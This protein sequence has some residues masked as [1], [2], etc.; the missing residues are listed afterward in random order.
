M[1]PPRPSFPSTLATPSS[2]AKQCSALLLPRSSASL[3][4]AAG[5]TAGRRDWPQSLYR[6]VVDE[7]VPALEISWYDVAQ[8][9]DG[10]TFVALCRLLDN[11]YPPRT[12]PFTL[13]GLDNAS[14]LILHLVHRV[15]CGTPEDQVLTAGYLTTQLRLPGVAHL[16]T[17]QSAAPV[18]L[19]PQPV[20]TAP[21]AA[22][23]GSA[24]AHRDAGRSAQ[25]APILPMP[26]G[27]HSSQPERQPRRFQWR[28]TDPS[29]TVDLPEPAAREAATKGQ[30]EVQR[31]PLGR[32]PQPRQPPQHGPRPE[33]A[34]HREGPK[35]TEQQ[36][37]I[38]GSKG[39]KRIRDDAHDGVLPKRRGNPVE[40]RPRGSS[41]AARHKPRQPESPGDH[42]SRS[43]A[44]SPIRQSS[45]RPHTEKRQ[46]EGPPKAVARRPASGGQGW[47]L[48][49]DL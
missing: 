21:P 36:Q 37:G 20:S 23:A 34:D 24:P 30:Q 13:S 32:D 39:E 12:F 29:A 47:P 5:L 33:A 6:R 22:I 19:P 7:A 18:A 1:Q 38:R 25:Q 44:T 35:R 11:A 14:A 2:A 45:K 17:L 27:G 8:R 43:A 31:Q 10:Q 3:G 9:P 49:P 28:R 46:Q 4:A 42:H 48:D 15:W 40:P 26:P 41:P 16:L